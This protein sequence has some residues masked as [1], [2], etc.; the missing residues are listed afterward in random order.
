MLDFAW[1]SKYMNEATHGRAVENSSQNFVNG[2][3]DDIEVRV[4]IVSFSNGCGKSNHTGVLRSQSITPELFI[5]RHP[6]AKGT[7]L[8]AGRESAVRYQMTLKENDYTYSQ[9]IRYQ[10]SNSL[11]IMLVV[12]P[13]LLLG[14]SYHVRDYEY[15]GCVLFVQGIR[16]YL[17]C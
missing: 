13:Y 17:E 3:S 1:L 12:V 9:S 6:I 10:I 5:P 7:T 2:Q 11:F 8:I 16:R 14:R 4:I 15:H